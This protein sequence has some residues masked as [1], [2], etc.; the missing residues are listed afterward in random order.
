MGWPMTTYT[1]KQLQ[2]FVDQ[3]K[4][5]LIS[6]QSSILE[7]VLLDIG[8]PVVCSKAFIDFCRI[9]NEKPLVLLLSS[10]AVSNDMHGDWSQRIL[11]LYQSILNQGSL[12][13]DL[14]AL[15]KRHVLRQTLQ[16]IATQTPC[17]FGKGVLGSAQDVQIAIELL[18]D[19]DQSPVAL[20]L[21]KLK[22]ADHPI[23]THLLDLA[24]S[25]LSRQSNNGIQMHCVDQW[26][27]IFEFVHKKM[28]GPTFDAVRE[29]FALI[30]AENHLAAKHT[31]Q[32]LQ[33]CQQVANKQDTLKAHYYR[34]KALCIKNDLP[35][36]LK[37]MDDLLA[38]IADQPREWLEAAFKTPGGGKYQF[39]LEAAQ[40]ALRD[41]QKVMSQI[42]KK[43]FLVSGT[44]LGYERVGNF[45]SHDKDI[46][47]GIFGNENQFEV[48]QALTESQFFH[49]PIRDIQLTHNFYIPSYHVKTKMAIDVFVYHR[50]A[51]KLR[52]GV[53]NTFGYLQNFD[54]TPFGL[55]AIEFVGV[56][57]HAPDHIDLN[58]QENFGDWRTPDPHYISHL[59]SPSTVDVGGPIYLLVARLELLRYIVEEKRIKGSRVCDILRG[60]TD[61]PLGMSE[62]L[63]SQIEEQYGFSP[64]SASLTA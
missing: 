63:L 34:A 21:L 36:S 51:N 41:M 9:R 13:P 32:T 6:G 16:W 47:V 43:I 22:W 55:Q 37:A 10:L 15:S 49:V 35:G 39:D 25:L 45:L 28:V 48:I 44:L 54:F 24:K 46:D 7:R 17:D 11:D 19:Y 59:E 12:S 33:W 1:K 57:T 60:Y 40:S 23:D 14:A 52:T 8:L 30:I 27:H 3:L 18:L 26:I 42:D 50:V 62:R 53:Q 61:H 56:P 20:K 38:G 64:L 5:H 58:L 29:Q 4:P 31:D 2:F